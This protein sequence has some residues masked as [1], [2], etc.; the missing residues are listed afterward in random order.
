MIGRG[1]Q[2]ERLADGTVARWRDRE[3]GETTQ[4]RA[5]VY[6]KDDFNGGAPGNDWGTI[7]V[8]TA[9]TLTLAPRT[10]TS[11]GAFRLA[12]SAT[13]EAQEAGLYFGDILPFRMDL[14]FQWEAK[15][16]LTSA[17]MVGITMVAGLA[18][19]YASTKDDVATNAWFRMDGSLALKAE[20][21]DAV[22]NTDDV[23]LGITWVTGASKILRIDASNLT[24]VKFFVD[25]VQYGT[26]TNF[27]VSGLTS[28]T[29]RVQP[30]LSLQKASGTTLATMDVEYVSCWGT[31]S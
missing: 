12:L 18:S 21:D 22:T 16:A 30:I 9:G 1:T 17:S 20:T 25:G 14:N 15:I 27:L 28:T 4:I 31:R 11:G 26:G 8:A 29:A 23:A 5:P 24:S 10:G 6:F 13:N 7:E 19:A 3:T 2:F